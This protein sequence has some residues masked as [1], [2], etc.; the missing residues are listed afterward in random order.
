MNRARE[1]DERTPDRWLPLIAPVVLILAAALGGAS[2]F[3]RR[4]AEPAAK[5]PDP[6]PAAAG[7]AI[8]GGVELTFRGTV[9]PRDVVFVAAPVQGTIESLEV[10]PGAEVIEGQLLGR[11]KNEGL[12][13]SQQAA[14]EELDR[15]RTKLNNL[16]SALIA[17]RLEASRVAADA[18]RARGEFDRLDKLARRQQMLFQQG[19]TPRLSHEKAQNEA[20]TARSDH[21]TLRD[22]ARQMQEKVAGMQREIEAVRK[23]IEEKESGFEAAKADLLAAEMHAPKD[24]V[25]VATRARIGDDVDPSMEDL[26]QIAVDS[27]ALEVV[28]EPDPRVAEKLKDG[29]PALVQVVEFSADAIQGE[30][31]RDEG[32]RF[33]VLFSGPDITFRPGLAAVVKIKLP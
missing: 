26:I 6:V 7:T 4:H 3:L 22:L 31:K 17:A 11:V 27:Q 25:V 29:L 33:R 30:L 14:Q 13:S 16:E 19:A 1:S 23:A 28:I 2:F 32:G 18:D 15:A 10:E 8:G 12:E 5:S 24:G 21:D 9:Q 20:A